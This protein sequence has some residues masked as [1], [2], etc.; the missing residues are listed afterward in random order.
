MN[1]SSLQSEMNEYFLLPPVTIDNS[2]RETFM[3]FS[4]FFLFLLL[5]FKY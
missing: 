1:L 3:R 5:M 4:M 2:K